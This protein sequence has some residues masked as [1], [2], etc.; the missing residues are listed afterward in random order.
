MKQRR[1]ANEERDRRATALGE[2]ERE[3]INIFCWCNRCGHNA[4]L[5]VDLFIAQLGPNFPVPD[6]GA[7]TRCGGCGGKDVATRPAW[8]SL[9]Q[10]AH[11][12]PTCATHT[13]VEADAA[14]ALSDTGKTA[15]E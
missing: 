10:V 5:P 8:P 4:V 14:L 13:P 2:L 1:L 9:G 11:H 15:A 12:Q 3:A 7:H 6:V